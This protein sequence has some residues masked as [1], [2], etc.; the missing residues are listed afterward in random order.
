[1][2]ISNI[3]SIVQRFLDNELTPLSLDCLDLV[4]VRKLSS[5]PCS[6]LFLDYMAEASDDYAWQVGVTS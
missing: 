5:A 1:M 3:T 2:N 4:S 6:H